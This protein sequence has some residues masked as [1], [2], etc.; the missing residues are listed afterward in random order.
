V[1]VVSTRCGG[2]EEF[3]IDERTGTLVD[4]DPRQMAQAIAA[5]LG[6]P[7]LREKMGQAARRLVEDQYCAEKMQTVFAEAFRN[8]FPRLASARSRIRHAAASASGPATDWPL[9]V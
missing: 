1:P 5:I 9:H 7:T 8:A 3:V 6:N 4:A 2:P